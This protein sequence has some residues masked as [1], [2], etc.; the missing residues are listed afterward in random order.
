M[1]VPDEGAA[2][3]TIGSRVLAL[4]VVAALALTGC[5]DDQSEDAS[6]DTTG[7]TTTMPASDGLEVVLTQDRCVSSSHETL[8]GPLSLVLTNDSELTTVPVYVIKLTEGHTYADLEELQDAAGGGSAYFARPEWI[9][10]ALRSFEQIP[11]QLGANQTQYVFDLDP[12][13]YAI[14]AS[15]GRPEK[16]WLCGSLAVSEA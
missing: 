8:H 16:I 2:V 6:A 15:G 11:V 4:V 9:T 14:Y 10:Y 5:S 1:G 13:E 3:D 12:G 7:A